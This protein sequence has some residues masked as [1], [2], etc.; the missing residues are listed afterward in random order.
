L[1]AIGWRADKKVKSVKIKRQAL[2]ILAVLS[3]CAP[4]GLATQSG[5]IAGW[6]YNNYGQTTS[7]SATGYTALA[8]GEFHSLALRAD[9]TIVGWGNNWSG[10]ATPPSAPGFTAIAAGAFHSV[11]LRADGSIAAWGSSGFSGQLTTPPDGNNFIA[12]SAGASHS[13]AL[14]T[15]GTIVGWGDNWTGAATPP[16]GNDFAAIAS[17]TFHCLALR[18]DGTIVGWG[19]NGYGEATPPDGNDFVAIAAGASHSVALKADGSIVA[20]G[21]NDYGQRNVPSGRGFAAIAAGWNH[22]LALLANGSIVGWGWNDFGQAAAPSE[23]GFTAIAAGW[24]HSLALRTDGSIVGW[25][26]NSEGQATPPGGTDFTA[27]AAGNSHSLALRAN[28]S[29]A[30][31]GSNYDPNGLE[32][33]G[34]ATAP[35][36][37]DFVAIAAGGWHSL[38]LRANGCIVGWGCNIDWNGTS[39]GQATPPGGTGFAAIAA[40]YFH[41][42]ALR[43]D[44]SIAGWGADYYGQATPPSSGRFT[45]IAAGVFHSLALRADGT[46]AG[47]GWNSYGQATPPDGNDFVAIAAGYYHSL[48]LRANGSIVGW[49]ENAFGQTT[50]PPG[51]DFV[52]I[53]LRD[54]HNLALRANGSIVGWGYNGYGQATPP[55]G[56]GYRAIAAGGAHSLALMGPC[57]YPLAGDLND[58]CHVNWLDLAILAGQWLQLPGSPSADLNDSNTVDFKD[59]AILASNWLTVPVPDIVGLTQEEAESVIV[60]GGLIVNVTYEHS[61]VVPAG[62]VISQSISGGTG[63]AYGTTVEIMVSLGPVVPDV[64]GM[65]E[66]DARAAIVASGL[67]VGNVTYEYST[68]VAEGLVIS[69]DPIAGT[70]VAPGAVV[71]IVVSLGPPQVS[72][73]DVTVMPESQAEATIVTSGLVVGNV[74]SQY[75]D[76]WATGYVMGQSPAEGSVVVAGTAVDIVVSLGPHPFRAKWTWVSGSD[77]ASQYGVYGT[78]GVP[79]SDNVPGA[80]SSSVSWID[81][82]GNFR[83]FGGNGNAANESGRL[84]DLWKFDGDNWIWVSGSNARN[85]YGVYGTKGVAA[86]DNAPG[87][88]Y[89]SI[90]WMD[91]SGNLWLFGGS[92]YAVSGSGYL[93]DLWKFDGDNWTWVSGSST[94]NQVGVYGTKGAAASGNMPGARAYS[95]SWL[96]GSGNL[97]LFGGYGYAASGEGYLNDLWKFDGTN[98]TW[99]WGWSTINQIGVYGT[100]GAAAS[101]NVPGARSGSVSWIDS[102]GTFWLF[103]GYGFA[104]SGSGRL[105]DLW[106]FDGTNWTWVSGSTGC[107]QYGVYGIKGVPA[108]GNVPG[109]RNFPVSWLDGSDNLW[110]FGGIG[111]AASGSAYYLNDLWEFDGANWTWIGGGDTISENGVYGTKGAA[112]WDNVPGARSGLVSWVDASG[113]FWFFGG[114]GYAASGMGYLNDLWRFGIPEQAADINGDKSIDPLDLMSLVSQWESGPAVSSADIAPQPAGDRNVNFRDFA[115][116]A[117][118]WMESLLPVPA[119]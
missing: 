81:S 16:D 12:I 18:A 84:N 55:R 87:A 8:A 80:R 107:G 73:P 104:A 40:G 36:G 22:S 85:Q 21:N 113:K 118:H 38:A 77:A 1:Q 114:Y 51:T 94:I 52:A 99:V 83:L 23:A 25:G 64:I 6:G 44:G 11:A 28:G 2:I 65:T 24:C 34:Q 115:V 93:N 88:R 67:A 50:P 42:L 15:D 31:W 49:G 33:C 46:I 75:D 97:W 101:S 43:A 79:S 112:A 106:K 96:D 66:A 57:L 86:S 29:I 116:L 62:L 69:Q 3:L 47:W 58:D 39:T 13:L 100:K 70:M 111:Y 91:A 5:H 27:I 17:G 109:A 45:A 108:S 76:E 19:A 56:M 82:N 119:P 90:S 74:T 71:G 54:G 53:A 102:S 35:N 7:P 110:L 10:V 14:R 61:A 89:G 4:T 117:S 41:S 95:V 32:Y 60:A 48:A 59:M 37:N 68:T 26:S 20:W 78:K 92:G 30:G 98:W 9:G 72:V 105:N 103:G 63:A